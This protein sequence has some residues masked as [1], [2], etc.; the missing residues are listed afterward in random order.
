[1]QYGRVFSTHTLALAP[2]VR[3]QGLLTSPALT[4]NSAPDSIRLPESP[5]PSITRTCL[6]LPTE[7]GTCCSIL[8]GRHEA[9]VSLF[10]NFTFL[11]LKYLFK[12]VPKPDGRPAGGGVAVLPSSSY[13]WPPSFPR[14]SVPL[15]HWFAPSMAG[16]ESLSTMSN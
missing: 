8:M 2:Y 1:M 6:T 5:G 3:Q 15:Y 7:Q 13:L 14:H 12:V 4:E 10:V 9:L 16:V 11:L